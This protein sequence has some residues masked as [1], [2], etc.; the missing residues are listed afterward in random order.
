MALLDYTRI[1]NFVK[2]NS[3]KRHRQG[4]H[5]GKKAARKHRPDGFVFATVA[6]ALFLPHIL[7]VTDTVSFCRD[8]LGW[9]APEAMVE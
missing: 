1:P 9:E 4:P 6:F 7:A 3:R 2:E 8:V 5:A